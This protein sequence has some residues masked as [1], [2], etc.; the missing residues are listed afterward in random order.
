MQVSVQTPGLFVGRKFTS[1]S[2]S[3]YDMLEYEKRSSVI[4][5]PD[6]RIVFEMTDVEVPKTWSQLATDIVVSKYFRTY[7]SFPIFLPFYSGIPI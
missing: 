1:P 7:C 6:G 5:E 2:T 3:P 4:K